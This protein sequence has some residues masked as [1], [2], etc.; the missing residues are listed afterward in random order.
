MLTGKGFL[1]RVMEYS[2]NRER[3]G[4]HNTMNVLNAFTEL[5]TLKWLLSG[6]PFVVQQ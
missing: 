1:F 4:L 3:W 2:G 5:F 6:V